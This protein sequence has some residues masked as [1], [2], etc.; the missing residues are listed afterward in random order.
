VKYYE[1]ERV[2]YDFF[3][4]VTDLRERDGT[5]RFFGYEEHRY[6]IRWQELCRLAEE[7]AGVADA[8][9]WDVRAAGG[10][11]ESLGVRYCCIRVE[12]GAGGEWQVYWS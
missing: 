3:G 5:G 9:R 2:L 8:Y 10:L 11:L 7:Y 4:C 12:L 1:S 6:R